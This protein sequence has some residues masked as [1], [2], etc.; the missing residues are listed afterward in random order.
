MPPGAGIDQAEKRRRSHLL[1]IGVDLGFDDTPG[2]HQLLVEQALRLEA[3][4]QH[5]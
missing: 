2:K 3:G 4:H 5:A 1:G